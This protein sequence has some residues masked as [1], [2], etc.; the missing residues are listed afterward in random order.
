MIFIETSISGVFIVEL[1][2]ISDERG[3]FSRL[4]CAEE[5]V[6]IM[7]NRHIAQINH[8]YTRTSGTI[9]GLHFQYPPKAEMKLIQCIRGKVFDVVV[10]IRT[11]SP[12]FLKWFGVILSEEEHKMIV[13]PEGCAHG[14]QVLSSNSELLYFHTNYY[15]PECEDGLSVMDPKIAIKWPIQIGEISERD[16][17]HQYINSDFL[18][19][20]L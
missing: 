19:V 9:R 10:D 7:G 20:I 4:Y 8:S 6:K 15:S 11:N 3:W 5:L 17:N 13:I 14:F 2:R 18:G 12:T 1:Q 16:L